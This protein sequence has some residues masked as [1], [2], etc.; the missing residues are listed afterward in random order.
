MENVTKNLLKSFNWDVL[1]HPQPRPSDFHLFLFLKALLVGERFNTDDEL[2]TCLHVAESTEAN[3]LR[4]WN[5][6]T[7][8]H[9][10]INASEIMGAM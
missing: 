2:K 10:T 5:T 7:L 3:F 4:G 6:K 8:F 9:A 1:G